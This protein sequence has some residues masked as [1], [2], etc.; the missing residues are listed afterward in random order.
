MGGGGDEKCIENGRSKTWGPGNRR[1]TLITIKWILVKRGVEMVNGFK[2]VRA[3]LKKGT[4]FNQRTKSFSKYTL[5]HGG[6]SYNW[7]TYLQIIYRQ[8]KQKMMKGEYLLYW[9]DYTVAYI[10]VLS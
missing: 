5:P 4:F 1:V 8:M 2:Q 7:L 9:K 3:G 10:R 6:E